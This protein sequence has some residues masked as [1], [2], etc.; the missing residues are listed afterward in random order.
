M[1]SWWIQKQTS[2]NLCSSL[3][4]TSSTWIWDQE[5]EFH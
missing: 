2:K 3:G 5:F 4:L 1:G